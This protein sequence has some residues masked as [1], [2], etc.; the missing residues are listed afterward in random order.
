MAACVYAL[1]AIT[2]LVCSFLLL[3]GYAT[4][5]ARLL[6]WSG[7]CFLGLFVKNALVFAD[8]ILIPEV[9]LLF[10]RNLTALISLLLLVYGMILESD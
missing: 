3:R 7:L 9:S 8:V 6:F 4:S 5:K 10:W 1:C 2:A